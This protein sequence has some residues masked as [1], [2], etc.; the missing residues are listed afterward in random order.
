MIQNQDSLNRT[1]RSEINSFAANSQSVNAKN[2]QRLPSLANALII[3]QCLRSHHTKIVAAADMLPNNFSSHD[4][5]S[6]IPLIG[7]PC[8][9]GSIVE[10]G[11]NAIGTATDHMRLT[12][13]RI[14]LSN[15]SRLMLKIY[16][17]QQI[18]GECPGMRSQ[19]AVRWAIRPASETRGTL[20]NIAVER[21][22]I[23]FCIADDW[24][25]RAGA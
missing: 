24:G 10:C 17:F 21:P 5:F 25:L 11:F 15:Y 12:S 9:L 13:T 3:P 8:F 16:E 18:P 20:N 19:D 1:C 2:S 23:L 7:F 4:T 14:Q 6:Q 22:N